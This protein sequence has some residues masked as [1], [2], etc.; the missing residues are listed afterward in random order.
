MRN[1]HCDC[2]TISPCG[3]RV[4]TKF[5]L[6]VTTHPGQWGQVAGANYVFWLTSANINP[7]VHWELE[8]HSQQLRPGPG[9]IPVSGIE[10]YGES[11]HC[12]HRGTHLQSPHQGAACLHQPIRG[13]TWW[14][15]TNQRLGHSHP[16]WGQDTRNY[17][18]LTKSSG[19]YPG[20]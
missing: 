12:D 19:D 7:E 6:D 3:R 8:S 2:E 20:L 4:E 13:Q 11:L 10:S 18:R 17:N 16:Y 5:S 14:P 15:V 9:I 1:S